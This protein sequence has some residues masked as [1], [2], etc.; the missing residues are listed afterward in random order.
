VPVRLCGWPDGVVALWEVRRAA[1]TDRWRRRLCATWKP[2]AIEIR[3]SG[4][5]WPHPGDVPLPTMQLTSKQSPYKAGRTSC[6]M[7]GRDMGDSVAGAG[8]WLGLALQTSRLAL[9][10]RPW[11]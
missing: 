5:L 10:L 6:V 9:G 4:A 3:V 11:A 1:K 2:R 7:A 8:R